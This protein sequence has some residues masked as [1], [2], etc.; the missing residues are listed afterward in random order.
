MDPRFTLHQWAAWAPGLTDSAAWQDWFAAPCAV[1]GEDLPVL[2]EMPAM[3]R[4]RVE[5]LGRAALQV[6]YR[7]LQGAPAC[8][9][10]FAS[11]YG[12]MQRS[13]DLM[14]QLA[15]DGAVSPTAFS[16][17]VHNAFAAL[18]SIA[19]G[20]RSNYS[21]VA[22]GAETAEC[23]LVEAI[24][25]LAE[26]APEVLV[27][28]YDEPLPE[29][30]QGFSPPG[31]FLRAWA[32]RIGP[33]TESGIG[34]TL[35]APVAPADVDADADATTAIPADLQLLRFLTG[36]QASHRRVVEGRQWLWR[37]A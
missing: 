33:A 4:R 13:V 16:M 34:Y 5:R 35:Q 36:A 17:S 23:A 27:V 14:R 24:G 6:A 19:R 32:C 20:D 26:G 37:R 7:A 18:F 28:Y 10:V 31:E 25:L 29:P 1:V 9:A 30:L 12:D 21:A 8:P 11:R 3:M 2:S 15:N 22:A